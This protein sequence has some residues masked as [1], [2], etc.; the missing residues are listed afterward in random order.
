MAME[1]E[2]LA[3]VEA[4]PQGLVLNEL[5]ANETSLVALAKTLLSPR[6]L[7]HLAL[8][9]VSST[10]LYFIAN[11]DGG[12]D[13]AA[14]GFISLA[15]GYALTAMFSTNHRIRSWIA[16]PEISE[17]STASR[18]KRFF[19]S[20]KICIFPL[21]ISLAL[22]V[23][24]IVMFSQDSATDLPAV[25]P[26][27]LASLFV[28]WAIAQGVSFSTW[29]SSISAKKLPN[30]EL[31]S[32]NLVMMTL[33]QFLLITALSVTGIWSFDYLYE[34]RWAPY[35]SLISNA[36]FLAL[37][38]GSFAVTVYWTW[39][40]RMISM[41][42][43]ALKKFTKRWTLFAHVFATWH[44]LTVWRQIVMSQQLSLIHI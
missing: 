3:G 11:S 20:F 34:S 2:S 32:G 8:I 39:T 22:G 18:V 4:A 10:M 38:L 33:S 1:D 19:S 44:L 14:L 36:G 5:A 28:I 41:K 12:E 23:F 21:S 26:V 15:L 43:K 24:I 37:A 9:V 29:A 35:Q 13:F 31:T 16:L 30:K 42:D 6:T 40:Q 17:K 25:F 7:P 27:G